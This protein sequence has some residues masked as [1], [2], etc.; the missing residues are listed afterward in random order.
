MSPLGLMLFSDLSVCPQV[1][2]LWDDSTANPSGSPKEE[3]IR[4]RM[5]G[6]NYRVTVEAEPD[7]SERQA[8]LT[9]EP[10]L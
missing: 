1:T 6:V 2:H 8:C 5:D 9:P 10:G 7:P 4:C 3:I